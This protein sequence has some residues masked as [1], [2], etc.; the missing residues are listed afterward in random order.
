MFALVL[1]SLVRARFKSKS[2]T[3]FKHASGLAWGVHWLIVFK[4]SMN[5]FSTKF[6]IPI[7]VKKFGSWTFA[8]SNSKVF[9]FICFA[10]LLRLVNYVYFLKFFS[11][12][13]FVNFVFHDMV[14]A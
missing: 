6:N 4:F 14:T 12:S 1:A 5:C 10:V 13:F 11:R 8:A 9:T 3:D 7:A 2:K